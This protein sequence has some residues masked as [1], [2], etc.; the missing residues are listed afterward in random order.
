LRSSD[1]ATVN[2]ATPNDRPQVCRGQQC[3]TS[4]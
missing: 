3:S 4:S 2:D 1:Y